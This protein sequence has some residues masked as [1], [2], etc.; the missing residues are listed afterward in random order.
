M[1]GTS[2]EPRNI[3][4]GKKCVLNKWIFVQLRREMPDVWELVCY[5]LLHRMNKINQTWRGGKSKE[6]SLI[7]QRLM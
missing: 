7:H 3:A 6:V 5:C 1:L 4:V 2:L